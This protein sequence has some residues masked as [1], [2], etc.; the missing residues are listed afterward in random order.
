MYH[1][2]E[3]ENL[4]KSYI[5]VISFMNEILEGRDKN[6]RMGKRTKKI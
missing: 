2:L 6:E 5:V 4:L 3:L 1:Y